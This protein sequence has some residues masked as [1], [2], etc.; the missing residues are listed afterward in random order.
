MMDRAD[1]LPIICVEGVLTANIDQYRRRG[2]AQM[3]VEL[4]CGYRKKSPVHG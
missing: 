3:R 1:D 4:S 2:G